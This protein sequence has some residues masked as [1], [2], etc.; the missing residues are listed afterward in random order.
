VPQGGSIAAITDA[1][2]KSGASVRASARVGSHATS[3]RVPAQG[4]RPVSAGG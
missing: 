1:L 3:Y 4:A 2:I